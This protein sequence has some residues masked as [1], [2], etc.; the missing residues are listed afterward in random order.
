M[1]IE[2]E[3]LQSGGFSFSQPFLIQRIPDAV[4]I[5][6]AVTKSRS[7][8]VVRDEQGLK[9]KYD[10]KYRMITGMLECLQG[11]IR[12]DTSM[13][14]HNMP[15]SMQNQNSAMKGQSK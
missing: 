1:G 11:A 4:H 15:G 2:I 3:Q 12:P 9:R 6:M 7:T 5:D 14:T 10:W 8:P 13:G